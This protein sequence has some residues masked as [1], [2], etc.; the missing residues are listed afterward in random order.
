MLL[1]LA[2]L[3]AA[4]KYSS[5]ALVS[6][7]PAVFSFF[8]DRQTEFNGQAALHKG[9]ECFPR[10]IQMSGSLLSQSKGRYQQ[11]TSENGK[12]I[13]YLLYASV[14]NKSVGKTAVL[15]EILWSFRAVM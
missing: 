14:R 5:Q 4:P 9:V 13:P 3:K 10:G 6:S 1:D 15:F 8:F 11:H 2:R 12:Y 7:F